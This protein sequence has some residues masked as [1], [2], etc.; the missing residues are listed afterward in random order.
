MVRLHQLMSFLGNKYSNFH[1]YFNTQYVTKVKEWAT[2]FRIGTIVNTNMFVKSFHHLLKVNYLN[3]KQ[4]RHGDR[5][6]YVLLHIARNLIYEQLNIKWKN[7]ITHRKHEINKRYKSALDIEKH[8]T[9]H[10]NC[11]SW[12]IESSTTTGAF[13][14]LDQLKESCPC[15]LHRSTCDA[16]IHMYQ[17]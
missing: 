16:C 7:K 6:I 15:E 14:F 8:S 4:N 12:K 17:I 9:L 10:Q 11:S 5:L 2:C 1:Q 13:Y 3:N